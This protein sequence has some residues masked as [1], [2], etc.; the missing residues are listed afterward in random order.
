VGKFVRRIRLFLLVNSLIAS[1]KER[2]EADLKKKLESIVPDLSD[3]YSTR[4][5]DMNDRFMVEKIRSQHT[6]QINIFLKN[7]K[8][9]ID[10]KKDVINIVDIGDSSGTHLKYLKNLL[11]YLPIDIQILSVNLD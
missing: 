6:F 1:T 4:A 7:I 11:S 9:L 5:L 10:K 8:Y 2:G 3:Q